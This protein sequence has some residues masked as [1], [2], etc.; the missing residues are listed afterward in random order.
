MECQLQTWYIDMPDKEEIVEILK[1]SCDISK[2]LIDFETTKY[3][4]NEDYGPGFYSSAIGSWLLDT[5]KDNLSIIEKIIH[6]IVIFHFKR[7]NVEFCDNKHT[8]QFFFK[9][10]KTENNRQ[11]H[12]DFYDD[13]ETK[14]KDNLFFSLITY[15][16]D[17][18]MPTLL[19]NITNKTYFEICDDNNEEMILNN[20]NRLYF[21]FPKQLKHLY[22]KGKD[23]FHG[24]YKVF[25]RMKNNNDRRLLVIKV[26][27]EIKPDFI[28]YFDNEL[29]LVNNYK[30]A[31]T[32]KTHLKFISK[33]HLEKKLYMKD[34]SVVNNSFYK[35]VLK[36]ASI[37]AC[38]PFGEL[39]LKTGYGKYD[40]FIFEVNPEKYVEPLIVN[41]EFVFSY[42]YVLLFILLIGIAYYLFNNPEIIRVLHNSILPQNSV[43]ISISPLKLL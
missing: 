13:Y 30:I 7:L 11:L 10:E 43:D 6:D 38:Y 23:H 1:K 4:R 29:F 17:N 27:D 22:F 37:S 20:L 19:T 2:Y 14:T 15:L 28:N 32:D 35:N 3:K 9:S 39:I 40:T 18:E 36:D 24:H 42:F 34:F 12:L 21:S 41:N 16:D 25:E 5:K 8:I 31:K 26:W 33:P